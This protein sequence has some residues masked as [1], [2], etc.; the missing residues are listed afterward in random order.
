V[1]RFQRAA[2]AAERQA[3]CVGSFIAGDERAEVGE[4]NRFGAD[5]PVVVR[6]G[7]SQRSLTAVFYTSAVIV[8]SGVRHGKDAWLWRFLLVCDRYADKG[9]GSISSILSMENFS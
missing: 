1:R 3:V 2:L 7:F 9:Y 4:S 8:T 5:R 6:R